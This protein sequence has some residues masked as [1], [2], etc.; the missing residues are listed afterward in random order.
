MQW[1]VSGPIDSLPGDAEVVRTSGGLVG[2]GWVDN[3]YSHLFRTTSLKHLYW[4][5]AHSPIRLYLMLGAA[6]IFVLIMLHNWPLLA[7]RQA[8]LVHTVRMQ[9]TQPQAC[10]HGAPQEDCLVL[11]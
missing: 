5:N 7:P 3:S 10:A 6:P 9:W 4:G 2:D 11:F 8:H 1:E